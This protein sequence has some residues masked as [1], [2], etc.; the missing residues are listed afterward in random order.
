MSFLP[1]IIYA[2]VVLWWQTQ[3]F[4]RY[5]RLLV[6]IVQ[7]DSYTRRNDGVVRR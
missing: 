1:V 2:V 3:N 7:R 6:R 4:L 5:R